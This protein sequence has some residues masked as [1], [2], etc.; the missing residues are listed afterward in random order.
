MAVF[1]SVPTNWVYPL[2]A[3]L[4]PYDR[5]DTSPRALFVLGAYPSALHV[6]WVPPGG[7]HGIR[8]LP[9][10]NEPEPFWNGERL[11][12]HFEAWKERDE[13]SIIGDVAPA[14]EL[15][16]PSGT[17]LDARYLKALDFTRTD[18]WIADSLPL[19][20]QSEG[21]EK[22]LAR[23]KFSNLMLAQCA[24]VPNLPKHPTERQIITQAVSRHVA[25]RDEL[26]AS[27]ASTVI[28]LGNAALAVL[29]AALDLNGRPAKLRRDRDYGAPVE[30]SVPHRARWYA[31]AHPGVL[32]KN[33]EWSQAHAAWEATHQG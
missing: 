16:G 8:A 28:T 26:A 19:Y 20:C 27:R 21:V 18:A 1:C 25:I 29:H 30:L 6:R 9:V 13:V 32:E 2:G 24:P 14:P 5:E 11:A 4:C 22:A 7:G 31:L 10:D 23:T 17:A 33:T 12:E 15:N 3:P